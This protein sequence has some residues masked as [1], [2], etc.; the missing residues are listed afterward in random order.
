MD[1]VA[2]TLAAAGA[3][4]RMLA[5]AMFLVGA[6]AKMRDLTGFQAILANYRLLPEFVLVPA[7]IAL[8]L[9]ELAIGAGLI[10]WPVLAVP[11]AIALLLV[12]AFAVGVN[13]ARG[14]SYIDCGCGLSRRRRISRGMVL[15]NLALGVLLV[16]AALPLPAITGF[17][18]VNCAIAGV[19]L[20]G[21]TQIFSE[22]AAL[23]VPGRDRTPAAWSQ[24]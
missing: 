4:V 24:I 23:R 1:V 9:V 22:I 20:Y 19:L 15:Q 2:T 12:F 13:L 11:A 17:A 5:A 3:T 21:L 10:G 7:S 6:V 18:L 14:R 16:P 8:V